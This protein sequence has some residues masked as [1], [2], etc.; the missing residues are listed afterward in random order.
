VFAASLAGDGAL[1]GLVAV[2]ALVVSSNLRE[3]WKPTS[4][5]ERAASPRA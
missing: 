4:R 2:L 5:R 1:Q 3:L